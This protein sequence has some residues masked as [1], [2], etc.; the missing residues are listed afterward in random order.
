MGPGG[1]GGKNVRGYVGDYKSGHV[2]YPA[3]DMFAQTLLGAL[4]VR[5]V[6]GCDDVVVE[7]VHIHDNGGHH[8]ARRTINEWD[9]D[10]F[11]REL[12]D[13]MMMVDYWDGWIEKNGPH[14]VGAVEGPHCEYC[15]AYKSCPA[16]VALVRAIPA[17]LLAMGVRPD[18]ESES[19]ALVLT[20]GVI[21][22]RNVADIWMTLE[23]ITDIVNRAKEEA[24]SIAAFEE[25][26]LPD[27]RVLGRL[28][29][30]RRGIN[31]KVGAEVLEKTYGR[32]TRDEF[33]ELSVTMAALRQAAVKHLK[34][35]EKIETKAKT[36]AYDK[37]LA[38][39]ER[40][41]G[42]ELNV[43]DAVKPHVPKKKRLPAG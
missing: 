11:A 37:L 16:K 18:P 33:V 42:L 25:V 20:P 32:A 34:Q 1:H 35:G 27:G 38:E 13:A 29:T 19:G 26:P 24:C 14:S 21:S 28:I 17:Q 36:G 8:K 6:Y 5:A 3:P 7:L 30:E 31:G 22:V 43:T 2:K 40:A 9:L 23:R 12:A 10:L 41:G 4:C 15:P 39:V